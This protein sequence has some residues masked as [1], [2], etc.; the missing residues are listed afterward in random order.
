MGRTKQ[1]AELKKIIAEKTA[2][3]LPAE[4]DGPR[5]RRRRK[6]G[7]KS[8]SEIRKAQKGTASLLRTAP[9]NRWIREVVQQYNGEL[10]ISKKAFEAMRVALE[11]YGVDV[12]RQG[13]KC[14]VNRDSQTLTPKDMQTACS[15]A[16]RFDI[17]M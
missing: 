7:A 12:M 8:L 14:T 4:V 17:N 10:Q 9:T 16:S 15:I 13:T 3:E 1:V 11:T 6:R 5:R 2:A